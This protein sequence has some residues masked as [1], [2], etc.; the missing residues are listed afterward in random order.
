MRSICYSMIHLSSFFLLHLVYMTAMKYIPELFSCFLFF[1][2]VVFSKCS[3]RLIFFKYFFLIVNFFTT[4]SGFFLAYSY[5]YSNRYWNK[6]YY[7]AV[8]LIIHQHYRLLILHAHVRF[9]SSRNVFLKSNT[10]I[11]GI[12]KKCRCLSII[13]SFYGYISSTHLRNIL[14]SSIPHKI[15]SRI[16]RG[17]KKKWMT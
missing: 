14:T 6:F 16:F 11:R 12:E 8:R 15:N 5:I 4:T 3:L 7:W 1:T 17:E 13:H 9:N 2:C 10:T